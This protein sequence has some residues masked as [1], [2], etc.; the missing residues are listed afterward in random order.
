MGVNKME[1]IYNVKI[2]EWLEKTVQVEAETSQEASQIVLDEYYDE[3]IAL[4]ADDY[5][6]DF[7]IEVQ[8]AQE[9]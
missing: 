1:K 4:T 6:G 2:T 9:E 5:T 3:N 7:D 8:E